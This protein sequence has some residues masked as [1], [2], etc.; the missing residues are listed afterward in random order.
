MKVGYNKYIY[1]KPRVLTTLW[2]SNNVSENHNGVKNTNGGWY[3]IVHLLQ[4]SRLHKIYKKN[5]ISA[6]F[7]LQKGW[8]S[9]Q[10]W[11][12]KYPN[13]KKDPKNGEPLMIKSQLKISLNHFM[14]PRM[15]IVPPT[16]PPSS[17][18]CN[19]LVYYW[20]I[21]TLKLRNYRNIYSYI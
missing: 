7:Q 19:T 16:P 21:L 4:F 18:L 2:V 3:N 1:L 6:S 17:I 8:K 13:S 10:K 11:K 14:I 9:F 5:S 20:V 15:P 12:K